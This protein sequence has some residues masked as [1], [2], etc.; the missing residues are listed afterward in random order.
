MDLVKEAFIQ[1]YPDKTY[2]Y[3]STIHYSGKFTPYNARVQYS[4]IHFDFRLS[5]K[6]KS[7]D[8]EIVLGLIQSLFLKIFRDKKKTFN[9]EL[10]H[11][12]IR[13]LPHT[14]P[15]KE[16]DSQLIES[17]N[18]IN[19]TYL[20]NPIEQ[21]TLV[22][23]TA[24]TTKLGHYDLHTDKIVISTIF[25]ESPLHLL[26]YVMYHEMLH[27]KHQYKR[28]GNRSHFHTSAFK[29]DE[30]RFQNATICEQE[31][32]SFIRKTKRTVN[33][34]KQPESRLLRLF[35]R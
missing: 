25:K 32:T 28:A 21:P 27:K 30:K 22:W 20:Q 11:A 8:K 31:L 19:E 13:K 23:G 5:K 29:K 24:S 18:R 6:W 9:T 15:P 16:S 35:M 10:Y 34:K 3:S 17:F 33:P 14:T 12:F 1:L 2:K 26:D 4:N 7:A